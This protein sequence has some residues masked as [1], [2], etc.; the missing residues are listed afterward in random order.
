MTEI[1][2]KSMFCGII[3]ACAINGRWNE[4]KLFHVIEPSFSKKWYQTQPLAMLPSTIKL[5]LAI[6]PPV[7][8]DWYISKSVRTVWSYKCCIAKKNITRTMENN[9]WISSNSVVLVLLMATPMTHYWRSSC[10]RH[11]TK[12]TARETSDKDKIQNYKPGTYA[13][14]CSDHCIIS[15]PRYLVLYQ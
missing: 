9:W 8:I 7:C 11:I 13:K 4:N 2:K 6:W 10:L 3:S 12:V 15:T 5:L 1:W 14:L